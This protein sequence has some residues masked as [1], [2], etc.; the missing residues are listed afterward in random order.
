MNVLT[1][2]ITHKAIQD[3]CALV[4]AHTS[5]G[6]FYVLIVDD[7]EFTIGDEVRVS[8]KESDVVLSDKADFVNVP[9]RFEGLVNTICSVGFLTR[10]CIKSS[11]LL[12]SKSNPT[13]KNDTIDIY[14]LVVNSLD[15]ALMSNTNIAWYV[16]CAHIVLEKV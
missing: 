8:F 15:T 3:G 11:V 9:N 5:L 6:I 13:K 2:C 4:H 10:F 7:G 1:G 12:D 14:A 16:P